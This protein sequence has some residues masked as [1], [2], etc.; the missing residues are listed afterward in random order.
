MKKLKIPRYIRWIAQTGI[1]FLILMSLM[2]WVL[3]LTYRTPTEKS[4]SLIDAYW[5]GFR[6]DLRFVSITMLL[7]YLVG[8]IPY[9]HPINK[10][11]GNRVSFIIW[12][13]FIVLTSIF[14]AADFAHYSYL[15]QRLNANIL[16][17]L[18]DAKIS[19]GMMWQS[20]NLGWGILGLIVIVF[21]LLAMVKLSYNHILSKANVSTKKSSKVWGVLFVLLLAFGIVGNVV[22]KAGQYPLRWSNAY[23][24]GN[25]Y[26]ANISL[27]PFQSFFSTLKFKDVTFDEEKVKKHYEWMSAYL[28]V[29]LNQRDSNKLNFN[30]IQELDSSNKMAQHIQN[31]VL[32]ICES[33]S[34]YKS[35]MYGNPL[36]TTPFFAEMCKEGVFFNRAFSPA[37]GTA[38]G[39]WAIVTGIPD[40][41]FN[42]T[43]SRNP[44]TVNQHT[45]INDFNQHEKF[46]FLG[47][48][49]SWA[50]I[51]GLLT[52]NIKDLRLY[53]QGSYSSKEIDVWGISDKNL[54]LEA[55]KTLAQQTKP[56][57]AVIQ[58]A[59]N[60][61]PYTIPKEDLKEFKIQKIKNA[62]LKK[63]GFES[64]EEYN[65]FRYTDFSFQKFIEAAKKEKYFNNTLFV[66]IG[67]HGIRGDAGDMLPKAFTTQ[68]LTNMH[69]PLLFYAPGILPA[70][71]ITFPASQLD[72]LP[73][74][75]YLCNIPYTNTTMGRN[76]FKLKNTNDNYTF[77][78][79]E[80]AKII[81]ALND[82][83]FF[84]Y[85]LKD[86]KVENFVSLQHNSPVT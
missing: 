81:G 13:V 83:Y 51:R 28:D 2:R 16:S 78:I 74:I 24:L 42:K 19:F 73:S 39:V 71:E 27:N 61:R 82:N 38:R 6:F 3:V 66:F 64:E 80:G 56:F 10:K 46:Y 53:E 79:D 30:R 59:D 35:S 34:A 76:L 40:V 26:A 36:N 23:T 58:T 1:M 65:A 4:V 75:A 72:V 86:K 55:N 48:S 57:F 17:F 41:Q 25:D 77:I 8:T 84:N 70:K 43:S 11:W 54:F 33:F 68:G 7:L 85:Q 9:L 69:V 12:S 45:I 50:N 22:Y 29:P 20:Y 63:Y 52:N 5:L 32:V 62:Q 21:I 18:H 44:A 49:S 47:G 14:Y 15:R 67:D 31:V 37:Y 60:H